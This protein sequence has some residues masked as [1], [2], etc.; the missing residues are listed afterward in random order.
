MGRDKIGI[1]CNLSVCGH[2]DG[3][4]MYGINKVGL[5]LFLNVICGRYSSGS[6]AVSEKLGVN[7]YIGFG[8]PVDPVSFK[9]LKGKGDGHIRSFRQGGKDFQPDALIFA[10]QVDR[11]QCF[12]QVRPILIQ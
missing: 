2:G 4:K 1:G 11:H 10:G 6:R 3:I 9:I 7:V 12:C 8:M 5:F